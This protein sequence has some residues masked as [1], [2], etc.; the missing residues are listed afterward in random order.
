MAAVVDD[1]GAEAGG[2]VLHP[3]RRPAAT[4]SSG[5]G[6]GRPVTFLTPRVSQFSF[7]RMARMI[8]AMPRVAI[9]R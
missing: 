9:A 2:E 7:F 6:R 5:I 3:G 4:R 1:V 8:S